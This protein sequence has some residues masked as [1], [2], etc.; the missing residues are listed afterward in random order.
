MPIDPASLV[1][2]F[3]GTVVAAYLSNAFTSSQARR[4]QEIAQ[5][6]RAIVGKIVGVWRPPLAGSFTR[7]YIEFEPPHLDRPVRTC[8]IDRRMPGEL[9]ASLPPVGTAVNIKY[10]PERPHDAVIAKLV[11][12]FMR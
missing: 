6:G 12:R 11:S 4:Q 3:G 2:F 8:H 10:L 1:C 7:L 5:R 9:S